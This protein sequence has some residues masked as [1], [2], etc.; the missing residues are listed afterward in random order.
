MS[1]TNGTARS[2]KK[3][4][5]NDG[6]NA[7]YSPAEAAIIQNLADLQN[8]LFSRTNFI[9]A[10]LEKKRDLE[11][12]CD[13]PKVI[14][15]EMYMAMYERE[16][17]AA[18]VVNIY[19]E[20]CWAMDPEIRETEDM[21]DTPFEVAWKALETKHN[22][23]HYLARLDALSGIGRFGIMFLG[24]NDG[25]PLEQKAPGI[26]ERGEK[27]SRG[28]AKPL[29][30][31]Y[32][33]IFDE[34]KV[35]IV[36]VEKDYRN[37]RYGQ[38]TMYN[39]RMVDVD[40][41]GMETERNVKV[42]WSRVIHVASDLDDRGHEVL[43][44]PRM[45]PVFNRLMD[46]RKILGGSGEMFYK[47][48]FPGLALEFNPEVMSQFGVEFG[49]EEKKKLREEISSYMNG[50]QRY[51]A[52][53]GMSAKSLT[54]QI[55]PPREHIDTQLKILSVC[56]GIPFRVFAGSEEA[57][58]A[59]SQDMYTWNKRLSKRNNKRTTP[60]VVRP[61]LDRFIIFGILPEPSQYNVAWPDLNT[62]ADTDKADVAMK[63]TT[64]IA[65]YYT[66]GIYQFIPFKEYM[67]FVVG[68][69]LEQ[70]TAMELAQ[71]KNPSKLPPP[72]GTETGIAFGAE[73]DKSKT[74]SKSSS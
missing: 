37:P 11:A 54:P 9:K 48:A 15:L 12:E 50:L 62:T 24:L 39:V 33:R 2:K 67:V 16:G 10:Q 29:Q 31:L 5:G 35:Q 71:K 45:R 8:Q 44:A 52:V 41:K 38:P 59:S 3:V 25:R 72:P 51:I 26:N 36:S 65:A 69:T 34:S 73:G 66:N 23:L 61:T 43:G 20:E 14:T 22:V 57:R 6:A 46:I 32:L 58:L 30:L 18:R 7:P 21:E 64:A 60:L 74:S 49:D 47:G 42:H 13:Y 53:M 17:V 40:A 1:R 19:P 28:D 27:E 63:R 4:I 70:A 56:L 68:F 55:A